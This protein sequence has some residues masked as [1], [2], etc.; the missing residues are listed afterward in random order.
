[1]FLGGLTKALA[2]A[3]DYDGMLSELARLAVPE[4]GDGCWIDVVDEDG[5]ITSVVT[6]HSDPA[7]TE[8]ARE[9]RRRFPVDPGSPHAASVAIGLGESRLYPEVSE[10]QLR[11]GTPDAGG[12]DLD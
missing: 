6:Q 3:P 2:V 8:L 4:L 7:K 10:E 11:A 12:L 9:L 1:R 5:A